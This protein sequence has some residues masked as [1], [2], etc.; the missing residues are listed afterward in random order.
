ML[1][2]PNI[3]DG[4]PFRGTAMFSK[5]KARASDQLSHVPLLKKL[6]P[7]AVA[8]TVLLVIINLLVWA[9]VGIVLVIPAYGLTNRE[10]A[11]HSQ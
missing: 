6:P 11:D 7:R 9:A 2:E 5:L 8:I 3:V 4:K 1:S 10:V